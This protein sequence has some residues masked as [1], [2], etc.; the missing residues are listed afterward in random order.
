MAP[1]PCW[2][3]V[4]ASCAPPPRRKTGTG[5]SACAE[6]QVHRAA[7]ANIFHK[8]RRRCAAREWLAEGRAAAN[9]L[10]DG[11]RKCN[12]QYCRLQPVAAAV[13][14]AKLQNTFVVFMH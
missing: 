11:A 14:A 9:G 6:L 1:V 10:R 13:A 4:E 5:R 7:I 3:V 8:Y 12:A 2:L